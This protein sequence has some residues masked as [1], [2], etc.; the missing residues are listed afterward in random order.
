MVYFSHLQH[1]CRS[2][3]DIHAGFFVAFVSLAIV[4]L[5]SGVITVNLCSYVRVSLICP[6][7]A[8]FTLDP[9]DIHE[10]DKKDHCFYRGAYLDNIVMGIFKADP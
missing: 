2:A 7:K 3:E 8:N 10:Q 1:F 4:I 9:V 5:Y 6:S